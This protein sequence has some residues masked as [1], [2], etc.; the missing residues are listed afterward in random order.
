MGRKG[1]IIGMPSEQNINQGQYH[2][3]LYIDSAKPKS[4]LVADKL[5]HLCQQYLTTDYTLEVVDLRENP[6]LS[7]Q[8]RILAVP[9]L[10]V[11][12]SQSKQYRFVGDLSQSEIFIMAIGMNQQ[13]RK[14]G[15]DAVEM[16]KN[17]KMPSPIREGKQD[18]AGDKT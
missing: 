13:A 15:Q 1:P 8:H 4:F 11:T 18:K 3:I 14:M 7:E 16:R 10:D 9:T 5:R 12:N 6:S 2:F 17:I